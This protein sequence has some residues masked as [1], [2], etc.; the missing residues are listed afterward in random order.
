MRTIVPTLVLLAAAT[1][2]NAAVTVEG[3]WKNPIGSAIIAVAPCG[4][5]LC[6]EVVWAS[7]R[8]RSEVSKNAPNVI[9]MKVLT[10]V[11]PSRDGWAGSLYIPDDNI[12][13]AATLKIVG[14]RQLK[15]TGCVLAIICRS[16]LWTRVDSLPPEA[17]REQFMPAQAGRAIS[18]T[19][20]R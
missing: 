6:G 7:E 8:G 12:H 11:R 4:N 9:G 15:L 5:V 18:A 19:K 16:Q 13:V 1:A 14:T 10:N 2:A 3:Y 20:S 17:K